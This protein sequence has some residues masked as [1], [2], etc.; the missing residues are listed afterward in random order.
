MIRKYTCKKPLRVAPRYR[1]KIKESFK[2]TVKDRESKV[3][4]VLKGTDGRKRQRRG[5]CNQF[6]TKVLELL[7]GIILS[8]PRNPSLVDGKCEA[9]S[10]GKLAR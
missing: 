10:R 1:C 6:T 8:T 2:D 3:E 4:E 5:N 9:P 7:V